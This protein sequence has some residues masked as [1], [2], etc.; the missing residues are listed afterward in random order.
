M[1]INT[2][3]NSS[4]RLY[5]LSLIRKSHQMSHDHAPLRAIV[6]GTFSTFTNIIMT[7]FDRLASKWMVG[8]SLDIKNIAKKPLLGAGPNAANQPLSCLLF[9]G[10]SSYLNKKLSDYFPSG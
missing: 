4:E 2:N 10:G 6:T 8:K 1:T 3:L 9:W 5:D 7:P